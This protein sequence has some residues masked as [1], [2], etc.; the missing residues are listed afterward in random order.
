MDVGKI[1]A[2]MWTATDAHDQLCCRIELRIIIII[3]KHHYYQHGH[4]Q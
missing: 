4:H 3:H 2:Y 1:G